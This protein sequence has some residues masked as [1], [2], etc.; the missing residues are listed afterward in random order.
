MQLLGG[1]SPQQFL[2]DY[3]QQRPLLIRQALPGFTSLLS[4]DELAGLA[5]EAT[6]ESRLVLEQAGDRPWQLEHGPFTESRFAS[7][8][9]THWTLLVQ[10]V[11]QW[12]PDVAALLDQFNFIP[13]W[14]LDDIMV[15]YAADQGSVGPHIDQYDVFLL[16]GLGQR[17]WQIDSDTSFGAPL[18]DH[19]D[20]CILRDFK[21][22]QTWCLEPGDMLYLPPGLAHY[23]VSLG[24]GMT[25]SVGF[26][27]PA[28]RELI[29]S[30][31]DDVIALLPDS[32]RFSDPGLSVPAHH[33]EIN[34]A[35]RQQVRDILRQIFVDDEQ[36]DRWFGRYIS[37]SE[38]TLLPVAGDSAISA[39]GLLTRLRQTGM[40]CR[41]AASRY[42]YI[43]KEDRLWLYV[44]GDE[45][46]L[47][48]RLAD[49]AAL[50]CDQRC[51]PIETLLPCW[52]DE[53]ARNVLTELF[54]R[55]ALELPDVEDTH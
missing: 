10:K 40:L 9:E 47:P 26:R 45:Y 39:D 16:Q 42:A 23:G 22:T 1:L 6:V 49:F 11:N 5:C 33:G 17:R 8:P 14:R 19:P 46:P 31:V 53:S 29:S 25:Y 30:W 37:E 24:E 15:S 32:P 20:L 51:Y 13:A 4:P 52:Q 38:H 54:N 36:M 43:L 28:Y 41:S 2:Q 55:N 18:L 44:D 34:A 35:A 27:A 50:L 12:V 21:A 7:L 48:A 3:W